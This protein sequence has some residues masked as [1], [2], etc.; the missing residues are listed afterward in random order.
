IKTYYA[1][2]MGIDPKDIVVVSVMPCT[3]KKTEI[4][5]EDQNASGYPDID[6]VLTTREAA[7]LIK[8]FGIDYN[9]LPD[10]QFDAPLGM[11]STAGLLFGTTG[12]VMEAALR[13]VYEKVVGEPAPSLDFKKVRGTKG[14]KSATVDLNGTKVKVGVAHTLAN[15]RQILEEIKAGK[16][17]YQFIEIMTCPGGCVNGGGQPIVSSELIN[18]G[19]D[20]RALRAKAI[21][22]SDKKSSLRVSHE[23]PVVKKLYEEYFGEPNSHKAHKILHTTYRKRDKQ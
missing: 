7:R 13:T 10:E 17:D 8:R 9:S 21:Y 22:N 16:C 20:P 2:K 23:N 5:R 3:A 19:V 4:F 11:G 1:E 15:A 6:V 14:I 18:A 12:G